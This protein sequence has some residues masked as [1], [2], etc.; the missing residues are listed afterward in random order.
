MEDTP[1]FEKR[2][3]AMQRGTAFALI[4]LAAAVIPAPAGAE[5]GRWSQ[6]GH[7]MNVS[8]KNDDVRAC[9]DISV[10]WNDRDAARSEERLAAPAGRDPLS[11]HLPQ[12]AGA[13]FRGSARPDWS[14]LAC[15]AAASASALPQIAV[16]VN[17]AS[18]LAARGPAGDDWTVF[19]IVEG[20]AGGAIDAASVNGP[21]HF[22]EFSGRITASVQNGPVG[23]RDCTAAIEARAENGP[24]S[25]VRTTGE[26]DARADNGPISVSGE[27]GNL[28]L[29]TQ[30]GPISVRLSGA[31]WRDGK[32]EAHAVNGPLTL[33]I[34]DGY[35]TA[36]LVESAGHSPVRCR[37]AACD[38]ARKSWDDDSRRIEFGSGT[39]IVSLSTVNGPVSVDSSR[40]Q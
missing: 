23:F 39:P 36:T 10:R 24:I 18:A 38:A 28:R 35:R 11:V 3:G 32:L 17:G 26:V 29:H 4:A 22:Q 8:T 31:A 2:G 12:N 15:K 21:L 1:H 34:P 33:S 20:P 5:Q 9:A 25:L 6:Q 30:N 19:F 14:V 27:A 7:G 40:E 37:A 13:W 16:A